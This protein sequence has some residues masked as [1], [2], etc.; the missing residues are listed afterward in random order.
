MTNDDIRQM[1]SD[2][3]NVWRVPVENGGP[4]FSKWELDFLESITDQ[5][6]ERGSLTKKQIDKLK[7][8]WDKI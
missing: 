5:F 3:S 7:N 1:I 4:G 6:S 8:I 2:C